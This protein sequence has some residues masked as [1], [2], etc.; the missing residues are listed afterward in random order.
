[1]HRQAGRDP[2]RNG[3]ALRSYVPWQMFVKRSLNQT[4]TNIYQVIDEFGA[5]RYLQNSGSV[6][7]LEAMERIED[8]IRKVDTTKDP[9]LATEL[10]WKYVIRYMLRQ[11]WIF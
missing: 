5:D 10:Q 8:D 6:K 11:T 9:V 2:R 1:M 7:I 3:R 4:S